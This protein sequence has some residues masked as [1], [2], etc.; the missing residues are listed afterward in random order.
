MSKGPRCRKCG[1]TE[2]TTF[3]L[4]PKTEGHTFGT[5]CTECDERL[6]TVTLPEHI[7]ARATTRYIAGDVAVAKYL[8]G[9]AMILE[10]D[11]DTSMHLAESLEA[12][13]ATVEDETCW[14]VAREIRVAMDMRETAA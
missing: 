5:I 10:A 7:R 1:A 11:G 8:H 6:P 14:D 13:F 9:V 4:L 3:P 2:G 12:F